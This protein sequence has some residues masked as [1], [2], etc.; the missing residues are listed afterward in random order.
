MSA[1]GPC[2]AWFKELHLMIPFVRHTVAAAERRLLLEAAL[3]RGA[4][5]GAAP[6]M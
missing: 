4:V 3:R 2:V 5:P 6:P 1:N